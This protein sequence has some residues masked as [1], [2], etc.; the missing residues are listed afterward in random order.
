MARARRHGATVVVFWL[1][2]YAA[3]M[4]IAAA[5]LLQAP[6]TVAC[7]CAHSP[8]STCPMHG[9]ASGRARCSWRSTGAP[10]AASLVTSLGPIG[11]TP[12]R[13]SERDPLAPCSCLADEATRLPVRDHPPVPPPPRS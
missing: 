6:A 11:L 4:G 12:V 5:P 8:G 9:G 1:L 7:T 3:A 13:F 2:S 10:L